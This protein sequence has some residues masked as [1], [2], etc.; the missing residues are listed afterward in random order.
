VASTYLDGAH[1]VVR[2]VQWAR[3]RKDGDTD[4]VVGVLPQAFHLRPGEEFLSGSWLEFFKGT[5]QQQIVDTVKMFRLSSLPPTTKSGFALGNVSEISDTATK[6]GTSVRIIHEEE[7]D[8]P[9]HTALRRW[10]LDNQDLFDELA[11]DVW[12]EVVLNKSVP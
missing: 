7:D 8:L 10:P 4:V 6:H 1:T 2:Y 9:A 5:R 11:A 12:N 3:L